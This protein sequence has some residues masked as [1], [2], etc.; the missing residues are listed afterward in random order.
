MGKDAVGGLG[1]GSGSASPTL[2]D[3]S[4]RAALWV[5]KSKGWLW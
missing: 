1:A 3:G 2:G 5:C 4:G